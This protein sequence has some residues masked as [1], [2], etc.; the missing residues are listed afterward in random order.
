MIKAIVAMWNKIP[1]PVQRWLKGAEVA[2]VT[3]VVSALF[4]APAADFTTKSGIAKY[5]ATIGA[6]AAG[7]LRLYLAQSPIQN[8]IS[9]VKTSETLKAGAVTLEHST[10]ETTSGPTPPTPE[11]P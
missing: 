10:S 4:A 7:C 6:V 8:V 2:V 11:K 5:A 3:G 9:E 1:Q